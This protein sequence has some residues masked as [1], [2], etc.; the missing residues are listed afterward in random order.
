MTQ[1]SPSA[2]PQQQGRAHLRKSLLDQRGIT[3]TQQ[4]QVWDEIIASRV[5]DWCQKQKPAILGVFWPIQAE[6]DLLSCYPKLQNL[7]IQLALPLVQNKAQALTFLSWT[8]G[9]SLGLDAYGI[10]VPTQRDRIV[11]PTA[12]LIPCVGFT[13]NNFRLGY[14]GGYYDRT[15]TTT[16]RPYALGIAYYQGLANFSPEAHDLPMDLI[17][18]EK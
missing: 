2:K 11:K 13:I 7:G 4:R 18:T 10:P 15:L 8:P 6:P 14:G 5:V 3:D 17:I 1:P 9:D 16:P 12:L